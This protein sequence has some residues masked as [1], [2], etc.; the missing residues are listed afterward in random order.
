VLKTDG[1]DILQVIAPFITAPL[2]DKC[3]SLNYKHWLNKKA[4][5]EYWV[6]L[7]KK[8]LSVRIYKLERQEA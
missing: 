7:K 3:L 5:E 2:I 6:F 8:S 1:N 4:V